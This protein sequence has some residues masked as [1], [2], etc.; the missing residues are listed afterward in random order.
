MNVRREHG[1]RPMFRSLFE[2]A[3]RLV[4]SNRQEAYF[5]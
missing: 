3:A 2:V 5:D 4:P 1:D